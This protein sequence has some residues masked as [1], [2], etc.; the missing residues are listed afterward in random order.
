MQNVILE[1]RILGRMPDSIEENPT[2]EIVEKFDE[3]LGEVKTPL[4]PY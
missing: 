3:L 2:V 1:L 4:T